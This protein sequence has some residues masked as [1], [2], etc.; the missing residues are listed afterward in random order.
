MKNFLIALIITLVIYFI[1]NYIESYK[2]VSEVIDGDTFKIGGQSIRLIGINAPEIG[3]PCSLEAKEKLEELVKGKEIRLERDTGEK[4]E[5]GRLLRYVYV[6]NLFVN[7][8]MV[9]LGLA[10]FE[11]I[12]PN[13]K[14]SSLFLDLENKARKAKR[15]IWK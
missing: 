11:E 6:D 10:K 2:Q 14:F 15:C 13:T 3:E 7:S 5:Y 9:R 12:E 1:W 4:D 8:E